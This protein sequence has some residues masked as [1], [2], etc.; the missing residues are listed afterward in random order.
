MVSHFYRYQI[1]LS[2]RDREL[3]DAKQSKCVYSEWSVHWIQFYSNTMAIN[4]C[5]FLC[6]QFQ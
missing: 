3:L 6:G 5:W 4:Y 1:N 2:L